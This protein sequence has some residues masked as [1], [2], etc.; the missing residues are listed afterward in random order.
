MN[1][2]FINFED[3][4][5]ETRVTFLKRCQYSVFT[6]RFDGNNNKQEEEKEDDDKEEEKGDE[7]EDEKED[8]YVLSVTLIIP[9]A[10]M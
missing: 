1:F 10:N 5:T 9:N 7:E 6:L 2:F 8:I 4:F 3:Y